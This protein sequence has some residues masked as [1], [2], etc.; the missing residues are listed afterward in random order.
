MLG[1]VVQVQAWLPLFPLFSR[2]KKF[3]AGC[4]RA[5]VLARCLHYHPVGRNATAQKMQRLNEQRRW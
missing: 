5:K 3:S 1:S 4:Q 2:V